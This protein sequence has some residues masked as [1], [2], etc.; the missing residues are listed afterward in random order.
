MACSPALLWRVNL[1]PPE[2]S[3]PVHGV[4]KLSARAS[5]SQD[6]HICS[7]PFVAWQT[8]L[9]ALCISLLGSLRL[10]FEHTSLAGNLQSTPYWLSRLPA[11]HSR[12]VQQESTTTQS[13]PSTAAVDTV[14]ITAGFG[15]R[16]AC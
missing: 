11:A 15:A 12:D 16:L 5:F 9:H 7:S 8:V 4:H 14:Q 13:V 2:H 1:V 3:G 6:V 10:I